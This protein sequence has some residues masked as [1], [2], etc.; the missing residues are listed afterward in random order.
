M[1]QASFVESLHGND[2]QRSSDRKGRVLRW[3][4]CLAFVAASS[5]SGCAAE[6]ATAPVAPVDYYDYPYTYY[7]GHIVYYVNGSW[8]YP[9]GNR[10]YYYRRVPPEL[11]HR[12][13]SLYYHRAPTARPYRYSTPYR[14]PAPYRPPP[15]GRG[16]GPPPAER[17]R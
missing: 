3:V 9:Y 6:V 5:L 13:G 11:A 14:N 10:W 2:V 7:D 17:H 15:Y 1:N 12:N 16:G 8:Y 4:S